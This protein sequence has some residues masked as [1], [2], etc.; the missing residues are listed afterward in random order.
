MRLTTYPTLRVRQYDMATGRQ[1]Y[2]W[3]HA[4]L[5]FCPLDKLRADACAFR[6]LLAPLC[7]PVLV[8]TFD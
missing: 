6:L 5:N 7:A 8:G 2:R 3:S 1:L 4:I